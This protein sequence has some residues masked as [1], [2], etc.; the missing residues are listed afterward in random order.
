[1]PGVTA[2][3]AG[4]IDAVQLSHLLGADIDTAS[5]TR[6]FLSAPGVSLTLSG[7]GF[8]FDAFEQITG[9][10][11]SS[12]SFLDGLSPTSPQGAITG[13]SIP[14]TSLLQAFETNNNT[15]AFSQIF[16]G[17]DTISGSSGGSDLLRGYDG[18]D[19]IHSLSGG[20]DSLF[21]GNG[22]DQL[23]AG[24][25]PDYLNGGAGADTMTGGGAKDVFEFGFN[26]SRAGAGLEN[27][28][29]G[30]DHI[31]DWSSSDFI[32]FTGGPVATATNY[33]E[34][35]ADSVEQAY[36]QGDAYQRSEV[37]YVVAQV[38]PD[39]VVVFLNQFDEVVLSNTTLDQI[40]QANVGGD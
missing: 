24:D 40:S 6:L 19:V 22:D 25:G 37:F 35:T 27:N 15:L 16:A 13:L 4:N 23:I 17:A 7:S 18:D 34:I 30:L 8:T 1:G 33:V 28:P 21:G 12:I 20:P 26:E 2:N 10:T 38:G 14:V 3:I 31:T 11:V 5:P 9:G 39:V 32:K 36:A 29:A